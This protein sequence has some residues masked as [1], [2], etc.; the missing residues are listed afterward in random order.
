MNINYGR[1]AILGSGAVAMLAV[2]LWGRR[3]YPHV[4]MWK[5]PIVSFYLTIAGVLGTLFLY[6]IENGYIKGTSFY[7]AVLLV[8]VL[9][10]PVL[11]LRISFHD[12]M[13]LIAPSGCAM[14]AIMKLDCIR[15]GCC[16]GVLLTKLGLPDTRFPAQLTEL[17]ASLAIMVVLLRMQSH[18]EGKYRG[19]I[20]PYYLLLYGVI[21]FCLNWFRADLAPFV[22]ILPPGN[23]WSV[24]A[25]VLGAMWL[26]L[27]R[28]RRKNSI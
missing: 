2:I 4:K 28:L 1:I 14:V 9:M 15:A 10:L 13:D 17:A 27:L 23:F 6:Y 19:K 20:Y 5:L 8:P 12:L 16:E 7:G 24:I 18:P 25:V 11:V 26:L 3:N 22:W 21:R